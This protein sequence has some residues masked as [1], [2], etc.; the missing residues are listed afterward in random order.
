MFDYLES[1]LHFIPVVGKQFS[2][3]QRDF[4]EVNFLGPIIEITPHTRL[5][6]L[7]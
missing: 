1:V 7:F 5:P 2:I 6:E 4:F 3:S